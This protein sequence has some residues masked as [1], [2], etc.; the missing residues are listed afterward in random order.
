MAI[1][2]DDNGRRITLQTKTSTYQMKAD[3]FGT[4]WHTYYGERSS[5]EDLS[6][7]YYL[8]TR[9]HTSNPPETG[10]TRRDYSLELIPQET[11]AF[12]GGDFRSTAIRVRFPDGTET[13]RLKFDAAEVLPGKY[14]IPGLPAAEGRPGWCRAACRR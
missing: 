4:L 3:E 11:S 7:V 14:A 2:I 12:G 9:G 13:L 1:R 8:R 5:E 6:Y 10:W